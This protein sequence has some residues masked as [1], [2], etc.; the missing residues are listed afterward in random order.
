M[1][2]QRLGLDA[3][4]VRRARALARRA[5]RPVV[6]LAQTH[7]TVSVERAV[8]RLAGATGA[9]ADGIPWVNRL[10]DAVRD[11]AGLEHGVALP[12]WDALARGGQDDVTA[13]AQ[14]AASG[15]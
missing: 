5:G 7:T 9:D 13:L 15:K 2:N 1:P 3:A 8:L 10:V 12:V 14:R 11:E 6:R 4:T